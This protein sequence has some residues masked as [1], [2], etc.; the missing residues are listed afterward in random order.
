MRSLGDA[1]LLQNIPPHAS[2]VRG[3]DPAATAAS[4]ESPRMAAC[5]MGAT[6]EEHIPSEFQRCP[7]RF[8]QSDTVVA[9][10]THVTAESPWLHARRSDIG[11]TGACPGGAIAMPL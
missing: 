1:E 9:D 6:S 2:A 3:A 11:V 5:F 8:A 10:D 7:A 4:I